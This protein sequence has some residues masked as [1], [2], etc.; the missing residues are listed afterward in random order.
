MPW[1]YDNVNTRPRN[2]REPV[3]TTQSSLY[4][5]GCVLTFL[6]HISRMLTAGRNLKFSLL[7]LVKCSHVRKTGPD[8]SAVMKQVGDDRYGEVFT[9]CIL[10]STACLYAAF[11]LVSLCVRS[12]LSFTCTCLRTQTLS[13]FPWAL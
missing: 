13:G 4:C 6:I 8:M 2:L 12:A 5:T 9:V 10:H 7:R 1:Q 3:C 11:C